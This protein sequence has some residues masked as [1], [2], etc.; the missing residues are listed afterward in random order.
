VKFHF[1][2]DSQETDYVRYVP[3]VPAMIE[4]TVCMWVETTDYASSTCI[5]S[6][7]VDNEWNL[8]FRP[9]DNKFRSHLNNIFYDFTIDPLPFTGLV[10]INYKFVYGLCCLKNL[11]YY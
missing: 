3:E 11:D 7:D 1:P 6:Y 9:E 10:Q 2:T 5:M 4:A 8:W